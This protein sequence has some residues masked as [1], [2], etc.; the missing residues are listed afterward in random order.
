MHDLERY[1]LTP[2]DL[3]LWLRPKQGRLDYALFTVILL[4]LVVAWAW[5]SEDGLPNTMGAWEQIFRI[6]EISDSVQEGDLYP[7][8]AARYHFSYGSPIFNYLAPAPYYLGGIHYL[9]TQTSPHL[10]LQFLMVLSIVMAGTGM[11]LFGRRR[12]GAVAGFCAALIYLMSPPLLLTVPYLTVNLPLLFAAGVFPYLLWSLDRVLTSGDGRDIGLLVIMT[13]LQITSH[14]LMGGL[15]LAIGV[16]WLGWLCLIERKKAFFSTWGG[17]VGGILLSAIYWLPALLEREA[18][19][20]QPFEEIHRPLRLTEVLGLLPLQ[21]FL[22]FNPDYGGGIGL[23]AWTLFLLGGL[24]CLA[25]LSYPVARK[26]VFPL[27]PFMV[28]APVLLWIATQT[29]SAWLDS[30]TK[31]PAL[32]RQELLVPMVAC[33]AL[34]GAQG[35]RAIDT[36]LLHPVIKIP[37]LLLLVWGIIGAS[38]HVIQPPPFVPYRVENATEAHLEAELRGSF[39]GS[40]RTGQLLPV[41]TD[42]LPAPSFYL[43]DSYKRG[44]VEKLDRSSQLVR[45]DIAIFS[46]GPTHDR[47]R[48]TIFEPNTTLEFLTLNFAGWRAEF[49]NEPVALTSAPRTGL[50]QVTLPEGRAVLDLTLSFTPPR[51]VGTLL[52]VLTLFVL[53]A[54]MFLWRKPLLMGVLETRQAMLITIFLCLISVAGI[55]FARDVMPIE[56]RLTGIKSYPLVFEGGVDLLGY[57]TETS[58]LQPNRVY[59]LTFYWEVSRPNLPD[60]RI[61][62]QLAEKNTGEILWS[63]T[64]RAPGGWPTSYWIVNR[65]VQDTYWMQIP[66]NV[67]SGSY[68]VTLQILNC[69]STLIYTCETTLP[70]QAFEA[71][72]NPLGDKVMLPITLTVR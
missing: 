53:P 20:W 67:A 56:S 2:E 33:G 35:A 3:P 43:L 55:T 59:P 50:I 48:L 64:H 31:F 30:V 51:S 41:D 12:W 58:F 18:V 47:L 60:Y 44:Q 28:I 54:V 39:S 7:R 4:C 13:A 46:H 10:S 38:L 42:V 65:Y 25:E 66:E 52:S 11:F 45:S 9:L 70:L 63:E 26:I 40:F 21:D 32:S 8:W 27:V 68:Q 71:R 36:Y 62:V 6:A 23:A 22:V 14:T 15:F 37:L 49:R 61:S 72:G 16:I 57:H 5:V 17:L 69:E 19:D 34:V 29:E 24:I 1:G